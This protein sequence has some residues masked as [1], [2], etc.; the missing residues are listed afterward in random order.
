MSIIHVHDTEG[1]FIEGIFNDVAHAE[2]FAKQYNIHL[3]HR[4]SITHDSIMRMVNDPKN[5]AVAYDIYKINE[6]CIMEEHYHLGNELRVI[7]D[8]EAIFYVFL[9]D[10]KIT[11]F[12]YAGECIEVPAKLE[13]SFECRSRVT[14]IRFLSEAQHTQHRRVE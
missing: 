5:D 7:I 3:S 14:A 10:R 9:P 8:G 11:I 2:E 12:L 4:G 13:H 1:N 6:P